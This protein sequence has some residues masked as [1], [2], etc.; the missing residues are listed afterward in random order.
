[1]DMGYEK[2]AIMRLVG[3]ETS[4]INAQYEG[5]LLQQGKLKECRRCKL[6]FVA[7]MTVFTEFVFHSQQFSY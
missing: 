2:V 3:L 5:I 1:M 7:R 4:V 6:V